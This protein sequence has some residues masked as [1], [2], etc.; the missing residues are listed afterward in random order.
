MA[1]SSPV[2]AP[3]I[4]PARIPEEIEAARALFR[5][6]A[7][8]LGFDLSFQDFEAELAALPGEYAPPRGALLLADRDVE[9]ATPGA[10]AA[11][12]RYAGCVA[13]RAQNDPGL[14][15]M[16]RLFVRPAWRGTGLGRR[17][18]AAILDEGRRLGYRR[19]RLD[20]VP[21]MRSAIVLYE[22]LGFRDIAPY[23]HNPI[24]GTR[25]LEAALD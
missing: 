4:R 17:L 21:Q 13:L 12:P 24:P 23:R 18:A 1:P 9:V 5:E 19:M 16:K 15:E 6:Y 11:A 7:A 3:A 8:G 22:S 20:T 14:C 10:A 2:D 25:Y